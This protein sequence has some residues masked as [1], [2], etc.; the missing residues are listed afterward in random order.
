MAPLPESAHN[1]SR[2][3]LL[4]W[5]QPDLYPLGRYPRIAAD[6]RDTP[7]S[8]KKA[9]C[10]S[11]APQTLVAASHHLSPAVLYLDLLPGK[12]H[13]GCNVDSLPALLGYRKTIE[14]SADRHRMPGDLPTCGHR[15]ASQRHVTCRLRPCFPQRGCNQRTVPAEMLY[16]LARLRAVPGHDRTLRPQECGDRVYLFQI[17]SKFKNHGVCVC[18]LP[19]T[20]PQAILT[21][22]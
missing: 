8:R 2:Q 20:N 10:G 16:P 21:L 5:K 22:P 11:K 6:C 7:F 19:F 1:L 4:A 18:A 14:L 9:R 15:H 13:T 17:L 12:Q 3:R